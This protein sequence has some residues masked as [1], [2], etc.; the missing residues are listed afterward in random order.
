MV[1]ASQENQKYI[2]CINWL[3]WLLKITQS[4]GKNAS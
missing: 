3:W 4:S 1:L 2:T